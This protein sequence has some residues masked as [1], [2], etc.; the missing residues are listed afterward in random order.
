[1]HFSKVGLPEPGEN[2]IE[3]GILSSRLVAESPKPARCWHPR[4]T[5]ISD[6]LK[7]TLMIDEGIYTETVKIELCG[8]LLKLKL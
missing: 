7:H 4:Q 6:R 8:Y 3:S 2:V 1:M 5:V